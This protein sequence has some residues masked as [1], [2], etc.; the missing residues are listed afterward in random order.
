M[1][2]PFPFDFKNPDYTQVF[3]WRME[4]LQRI[5]ANPEV[6]PALKAFYRDNPAQFIIDWGMTVDP[7]NVERGLPA[8]IPFLLFPK[9]EEWIQ[10]FVEHWR[11]SKPGITEKTRDMGMSW[12][13]VGMAASLC[14][15]NR[16]II[17]GFGSRKEEYV[18][19]IGSPKSLFDKARNFIGLLPVEFRGGWNPKAHAPHMRI[20]FP[21]NDSAMTG[22]AGD[23]I[24]RGDRTSFYIVDESAF[25]ERPYLVDASLSATT[26]CR[27]DISTPNGMANSFAERRHSGKVD[28]FT[29]HWRDDPRK[30]DAWYKKQC[31]ELDAVTV[32]QEIDINYSAS[33]E[34][35][36]IPSAWVQAA[37]DAHIKLGI[38]PTGQRMGALDVADEG[39][40]TNAF[41]S[42]HGFL[43]EDI[44]EWSGKGDD[45]FGTVQRAFNIC[46]QRRLEIYRFDSDGLGAGARGDARVINEQ[47]KERRERQITATPYRGSGSP[48]NPE[49]E[50]VPGE[51]GQQGRLNKD[52]F[53]NA[54]AQGWWRL[55]TLFRN[56]WRAVEE[57][58]PFSPDEIISISGSMK[59]KNKLIVEL[60][61]P[62][63]SV[64]GVGKIV[65]DKKPDGTKSPNL[66]DSAMI[67]YAPMEFTSMDIWDLLARGKNG[68]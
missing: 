45:I 52:F 40:D 51:Y 32:A 41:T 20:L 26:N 16:G 56:T 54:K 9:Q 2:I 37:V 35:V 36:L 25:L 21:E 34:G 31:E 28:V 33:V 57:K 66:A 19:K 59:L 58:M 1:P 11:T 46:D 68:S 55:R 47:R 6:L 4:R 15:F 38:Q 43:L 8:R 7:R 65:V 63:Y 62:T 61:Q 53:A 18:D 3:E 30:D 27:Q 24:G 64:N 5:R 44:E 50:A 12:L 60:S 13:T 67:A 48:A 39:K 49:D 29:F 42:R 10:W 17:A 22:E 14:L 23:G